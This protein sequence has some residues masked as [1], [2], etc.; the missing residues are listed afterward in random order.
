MREPIR[1]DY[2]QDRNFATTLA[3]GLSVL[4]AFRAG[5]DGLSNAEIAERTRLPKST[6][7]R[8]TFTLGCLGYLTQ[9]QRNGL[10]RP[11]PTLLA[12]GH[13]AAASLSFLDPAEEMMQAL[14]DETGTLVLFAVRDRDKLALVRTWR[15]ANVASIWLEVGHRLPIGAS[16]SGL[17]VLGATTMAEFSGLMADHPEPCPDGR[18]LSDLRREGHGQLIAQGYAVI[19]H[20]LRHSANISAVSVPFRSSRMA[21]PAAFTCGAQD[22]AL[23]DRTI[24]QTVGPR[25]QQAVRQLQRMMGQPETPAWAA[26]PSE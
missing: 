26:S 22:E 2:E 6:V 10:Y 24:H 12:M 25:L 18:P 17:A 19:G 13:V 20:E 8:L 7:S 1:P 14:A 15:P 16:S 3:R 5:D 23:P 9:P 21:G 11:G 4:R